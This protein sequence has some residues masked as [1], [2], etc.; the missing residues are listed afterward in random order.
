MKP[1]HGM[2]DMKK[3]ARILIFSVMAI[4][5]TPLYAETMEHRTEFDV[6]FG[7]VTVGRAVFDISV[8]DALYEIR[9]SGKTAGIADLVAPG[10]GQ[11]ISS[12]RIT[13]EGLVVQSHS[14]EYDDIRKKR[15]S[16]LEMTFNEGAVEN[17][18]LAPDKR[19][20]KRGRRWVS[21]ADDH[22]KAVIDPASSIVLPIDQAIAGNPRQVCNR[23]LNIYD[24]D[25]RFDIKLKYKHSKM[26]S[27]KGYK[28]L[29]FVCQLRYK[30]VSG[31]KT[32]R[33]N[34]E[35]MSGNT[36]MEIWLAPTGDGSLYTPIRIEV[37]TWIGHF[38]AVP[39]FFGEVNQQS[40]ARGLSE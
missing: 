23:T 28:G 29:A 5:V 2:T 16:T 27:T 37:P 7:F 33:R 4:G 12:G 32:G 3:L 31:H 22:L 15:T 38:S 25:T 36:D 9:A 24:G 26:I 30:P 19:N 35:Y 10:K 21:I 11:A 13:G 14:A 1:A 8:D 40:A 39:R 18:S 17:V 20:K 34:I 6:Y